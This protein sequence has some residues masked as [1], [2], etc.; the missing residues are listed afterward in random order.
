MSEIHLDFD[1]SK[2]VLDGVTIKIS[3]TEYLCIN[4]GIGIKPPEFSIGQAILWFKENQQRTF[5]ITGIYNTFSKHPKTEGQPLIL[6]TVEEKNE[7]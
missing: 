7:N 6:I 3:D 5:M 4:S 2:V 1:S